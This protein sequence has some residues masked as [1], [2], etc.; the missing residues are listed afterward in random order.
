MNT[1]KIADD[2]EEIG[3]E[4]HQLEYGSGHLF[5]TLRRMVDTMTELNEEIASLR[6][7]L[8]AKEAKA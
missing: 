8:N 2:L 4:I 5:S 7:E 3:E 1:E 6:K